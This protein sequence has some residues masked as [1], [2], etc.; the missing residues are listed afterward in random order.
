MDI[1]RELPQ[2]QR[3]GRAGHV[4]ADDPDALVP[5]LVAVADR[6]VAQHARAHGAFVQVAVDRDACVLEARG[7]DHGTRGP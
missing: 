3:L 6:A 5:V 2:E 1:L 4:A 7:Q